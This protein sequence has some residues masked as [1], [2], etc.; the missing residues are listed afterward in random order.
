MTYTEWLLSTGVR[1]VAERLDMTERQHLNTIYSWA[2]RGRIPYRVWP[3]LLR[4][5]PELGLSDLE[6]MEAR[7]IAENSEVGG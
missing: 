4:A 3:K 6:R 5:F 7:A 2:S 1:T